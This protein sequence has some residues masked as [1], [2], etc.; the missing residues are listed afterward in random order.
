[1]AAQQ[2]YFNQYQHADIDELADA[3]GELLNNPI[4]I[5][6]VDHKLIAYSS[7]GESTDQ[8]RWSTIMGRRV[9]ERVLTRLWKDGV[10]QQLWT[11]DDP[12]HV[13]AKDEVG[14][15]NRVAIAIRKGNDVLGYIWAQEVNRPFTPEDDEILRQAARVAVPRLLE[16]QG[17]RRAEEQRRKEFFWELLLGNDTSEAV[18]KRKQKSLQ[19]DLPSPFVICIIESP[20]PRLEQFLYPLLQRDKMLW[21]T[22][23]TQVIILVGVPPAAA[24][25]GVT[26]RQYVEHFL[27]ETAGKLKERFREEQ[28]IGVYGR[29]YHS[30]PDVARSYREALQVLQVKHSFPAETGNVRG[31]SELG[32]YRFLPQLKRWADAEGYENERLLLLKQYDEE[33][34]T[35]LLQTLE[36]FLDTVGRVNLTAQKLHIHINTLSY[37]LRRIEE[38]IEVDLDDANMRT[39]LYLDLKM[40]KIGRELGS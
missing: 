17:K 29:A 11:Q 20:E 1:M 18:L 6:D 33:N 14:L 37:R 10:F 8:A 22:D 2:G 16:R 15:G 3:I 21:V 36:T 26:L 13:P 28:T 23:G 7:H 27:G 32:I 31:Y 12:V 19:L 25:E 38:I 9:P 35:N 34:Q 40:A 4:T 5:E 30:L 39:S 24:S